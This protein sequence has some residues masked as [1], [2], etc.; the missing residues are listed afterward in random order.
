MSG[1]QDRSAD[2]DYDVSP[3]VT[4][5]PLDPAWFERAVEAAGHAIFITDFGGRIVYVNPAFETVTGYTAD[6]AVGETPD[7]LNSGHHDADYFRRLWETIVAGE[8]WQEEI[9]NRRADGERYIANQTIAPIGDDEDGTITHFVAI[10]TDI[11]E[12]KRHEMALERSQDLS[13]RTEETADVGGWEL[14]LDAGTL[15]WTAGTCRIHGV[16]PGYEPSI[17][18]AL[19]FYHPSDRDK[20]QRFVERALEWGL[21]YDV[22]ARLVTADGTTRI[23]R[24]TGQPIGGEG[25]TLLRGTIQ[26]ITDRKARGQQLMVLNRVLRHNLR[27][28]LN[29][30]IGNAERVLSTLEGVADGSVSAG[31]VEGARADL[32]STVSS[33]EDLL[34]VSERARQFD[35]LYQQIRDVQPVEIRPLLEAVAADYRDAFP[36]ASVSVEGPNSVVL[37][38]RYALRVA[39]EELVDNAIEHSTADPD[40]TL[41]VSEGSDGTISLGVADRGDGIP[42]MEREVIVEGEERPLKHGSGLGLWIVKWLIT[43]IGGTLDIEDNDPNGTVVSIVFPASRWTP[44]VS[45]ETTDGTSDATT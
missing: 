5:G 8:V 6:A 22:E 37:V 42:E 27:N 20:I 35:S 25:A 2:H 39:L 18:E 43:P 28:G 9:V 10:Q 7:L 11:T 34:D 23:V 38:N 14:D 17:D 29:V 41:R 33:A 13:A 36:A 21:P 1:E 40:V 30:V 31:A 45:N 12:R 4:T 3:S 24:T 32:R 26:D 19:A 15:R 16:G 44:T